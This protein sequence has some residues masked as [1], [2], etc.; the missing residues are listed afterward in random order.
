[1]PINT[2]AL[3]SDRPGDIARAAALL[4]QGKLVAIPT[5]TVYGLAANGLSVDAVEGIFAAKRRPADNPLILHVASIEAAIPLWNATTKQLEIA[6]AL[7][8]AFWPGPLS[9]VLKA[10]PGTGYCHRRSRFG[11]N[12]SP[13]G[14]AVQ[15]VLQLC[16][17]PLAAP[18]ANLSGDRAHPCRSCRAHLRGAHCRY[19]GWRPDHDWHR[20][21]GC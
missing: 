17:F 10:L 11:G 13:A 6:A 7:S 3:H 4:K 20:V 21:N 14:E 18:S 9:I 2:E 1:M 5:E 12:Q 15:S 19:S 8:A 16:Q